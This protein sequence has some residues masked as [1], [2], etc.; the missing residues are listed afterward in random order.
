MVFKELQRAKEE[1]TVA[2]LQAIKS[3]LEDFFADT[4]R[5]PTEAEGLLALVADPGVTGWSG[6]YVGGGHRNPS[7]EVASDAF[8]SNYL[9]DLTPTTNPAGVAEVLVFFNGECAL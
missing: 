2:E 8:G 3:G 6:P 4:G 7:E 9:Y 1:A 5:F